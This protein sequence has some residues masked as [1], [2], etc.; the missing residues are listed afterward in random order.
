MAKKEIIIK[1][2]GGSM[3]VQLGDGWPRG[4][5]AANEAA[6]LLKGFTELTIKQHR[7]HH[8]QDEAVKNTITA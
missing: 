5:E 8:H 2:K 6:P 4:A 1:I 3:D 7:P